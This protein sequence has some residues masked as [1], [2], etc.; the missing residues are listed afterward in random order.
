MHYD[1]LTR[2]IHWC[3]ALMIPLQL[4]SEELMK[5]PKPGRIREEMQMFWFEVHE[6]VGMLLLVA[7]VLRFAW[8]FMSK[9]FSLQRLYPY[10]F[11]SR[12]PGLI[13]EIKQVPS[14]FKGHLPDV[15]DEDTFI[16]GVV[17][18]LGLLLVLAMA[19]TG[20]TML[21]G[22]E[23]SG[24]MTGFIHDAKDIHELLGSLLWAY[25][26][27]HVGMTIVHQLAGH[28]LL[29]RIFSFKP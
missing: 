29:A 6:W 24:L 22:M 15:N 21:Y 13:A 18:G 8:A 3:F 12:R 25:L 2:L 11:A 19:M 20:A 28:H 9:E 23:D 16:P 10:M 5:R 27:A 1:K 26:I 7:I 4:L 14:W 17:H